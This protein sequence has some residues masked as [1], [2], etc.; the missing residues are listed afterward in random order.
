M[1]AVVSDVLTFPLL[2]LLLLL[3]AIIVAIIL[4]IIDIFCCYC[5]KCFNFDV[6][7]VLFSLWLLVL[8]VL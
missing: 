8:V 4:I 2:L 5:S 6:G 7:V 3:I 1:T